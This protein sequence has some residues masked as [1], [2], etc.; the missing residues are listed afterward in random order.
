MTEGQ[1]HALELVQKSVN[2]TLSLLDDLS[3]ASRTSGNGLPFEPVE[4]EL[5][6]LVGEVV[7]TLSV[8]AARS[9][10]QVS[11]EATEDVWLRADPARLNQVVEN[12]VTNAIKFTPTGGRITVSVTNLG[13]D[14]C[15]VVRDTGHG[16]TATQ[17]QRIFEPFVQV[18]DQALT[19]GGSGL[20][21]Y[22]TRA[23]ID[24]H[25]GTIGVKS[26]GPGQGTHFTVRLPRCGPAPGPSRGP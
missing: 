26:P 1:Q 18:H 21:L 22:I 3:R 5:S 19:K 2:K 11:L 6:T 16:M 7:S 17:M 9:G 15:L 13:G 23:I 12:L 8:S 4:M 25:G 10:V 24:R 20:G 14:A